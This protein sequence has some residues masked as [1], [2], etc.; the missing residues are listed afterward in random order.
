MER[1]RCVLVM[2]IHL[3]VSRRV[4]SRVG[5]TVNVLDVRGVDRRVPA[6]GVIAAHCNIKNKTSLIYMSLHPYFFIKIIYIYI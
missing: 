6:Q 2:E 5:R 3:P 1:V 4:Q